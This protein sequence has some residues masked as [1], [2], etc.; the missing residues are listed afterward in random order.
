MFLPT[1]AAA[2][3]ELTHLSE[4]LLAWF[5]VLLPTCL[6]CCPSESSHPV[7]TVSVVRTAL[8]P[9]LACAAAPLRELTHLVGGT[10]SVVRTASFSLPFLLALLAP[11]E[12]ST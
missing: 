4:G 6:R 2:L 5:V 9:I 10:V 11:P 1:C 3:R 7:R 8:P 12:S